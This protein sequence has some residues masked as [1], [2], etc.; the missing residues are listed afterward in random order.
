M[1]ISRIQFEMAVNRLCQDCV[2][3]CR[4]HNSF[5]SVFRRDMS[6]QYVM[7]FYDEVCRQERR[8]R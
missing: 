8:G 4:Q 6:I 3:C 7:S 5:E 2:E 1:K